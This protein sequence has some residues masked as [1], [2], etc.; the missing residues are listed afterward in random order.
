MVHLE[1]N[2]LIFTKMEV[3][4]V[5]ITKLTELNI[6][7][8]I[9]DGLDYFKFVCSSKMKVND[10]E[11]VFEFTEKEGSGGILRLP[12]DND[13]LEEVETENN[14]NLCVILNIFLTGSW[15]HYQEMNI[16]DN[17]K[18][19]FDKKTWD[20]GGENKDWGYLSEPY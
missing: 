7:E 6:I 17:W 10:E 1:K 9:Q 12:N 14:L 8:D 15:K 11:I 5:E 4:N 16:G 19:E 13:I 18:L 3:I 20:E 2:N